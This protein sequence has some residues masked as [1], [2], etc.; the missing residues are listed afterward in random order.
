MADVKGKAKQALGWL[1]GDRK[2]EAQGRAE[3]E[4][5]GEPTEQH[6]ADKTEAVRKQYGETPDTSDNPDT[7]H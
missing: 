6:V 2:V 7:L 5:H 1:T 4:Q 3:Q